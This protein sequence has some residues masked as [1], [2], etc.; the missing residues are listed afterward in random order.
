MNKVIL[1]TLL[2]LFY[3]CLAQ[4]FTYKAYNGDVPFDHRLHRNLFKCADC[5]EGPPQ[6]FDLDH[7][8]AH[9][10][11][12][13]CHKRVGKGPFKNCSGCHKLN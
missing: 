12:L 4:A 6:Y 7:D 1:I 5:H 9:K 2:A 10:L 8:S 11:C 3:T 13:G